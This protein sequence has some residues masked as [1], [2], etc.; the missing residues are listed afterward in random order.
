MPAYRGGVKEPRTAEI[1]C[2]NCDFPTNYYSIACFNLWHYG[3]EYYCGKCAIEEEDRPE[4]EGAGAGGAHGGVGG[5]DDI[6][7]G[8]N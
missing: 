2:V 7:N 1:M 8:D 6:F 3:Q 4:E 5:G